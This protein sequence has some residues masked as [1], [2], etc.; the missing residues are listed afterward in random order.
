LPPA[1]LETD[2]PREVIWGIDTQASL[3]QI[4][5]ELKKDQPVTKDPDGMRSEL[6]HGLAA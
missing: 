4:E 3:D 1:F 6:W 2:G 5:S